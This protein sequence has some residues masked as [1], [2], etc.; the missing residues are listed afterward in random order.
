MTRWSGCSARGMEADNLKPRIPIEDGREYGWLTVVGEGVRDAAGH[1]RYQVRCR[2]GKEYAVQPAFLKKGTPKCRECSDRHDSKGRK[3]IACVGRT[4]GTW[5]VLAEEGKNSRGEYVYKSRCL[6]C[7][8]ISHKTQGSMR[9]SNGEGC[10]YCRPD[11]H[12]VVDGTSA[13]GTL[14]DGTEFL[15]DAE[16]METVS[17]HYWHYKKGSGYII[18]RQRKS[19]NQQLHRF[20]LGLADENVIVDHANRDRLDC[21]KKNLRIVTPQQNSM[22]SSL[23]HSNSSGFIGVSLVTSK[24]RYRAQ[25]GLGN[26][27]I[28]LGSSK[29]PVICAQMYNVAAGLLFR[30]YAGHKNDVPE[31]LEELKRKIEGR[32]RP[33]MDEADK[34]AQPCSLFSCFQEGV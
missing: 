29:D 31:P 28:F 2:C 30:G 23:P 25:I 33:Y 4:I 21:R 5:E 3:R 12:F 9:A 13:K 26:R 16:D 15:I 14:P 32:C 34:A 20:L 18:S 19:G 24:G 8:G 27:D 11:Y 6:A 17:R 22:N 10:Q 7:G 1:F